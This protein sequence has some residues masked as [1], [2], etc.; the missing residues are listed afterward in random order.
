MVL[1][2]YLHR[3]GAFIQCDHDRVLTEQ[4]GNGQFLMNLVKGK[5]THK[6]SIHKFYFYTRTSTLADII[7]PDGVTLKK[8]ILSR[9]QQHSSLM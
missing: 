4:K 3:V 7:Y 8:E 2:K 1:G 9:V 5:D 6:A